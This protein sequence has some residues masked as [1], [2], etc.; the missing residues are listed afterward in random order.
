MKREPMDWERNITIYVFD[1]RM[2]ARIKKKSKNKKIKET[3]NLKI[4]S[5][6]GQRILK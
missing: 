3:T 5:G 4:V 2:I 6:F 1:R